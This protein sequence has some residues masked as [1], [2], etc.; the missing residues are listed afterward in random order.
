MMVILFIKSI[1]RKD[2]I[3]NTTTITNPALV[4]SVYEGFANY[5]SRM[6]EDKVADFKK[7]ISSNSQKELE[8]LWSALDKNF[9]VE[10]FNNILGYNI[11]KELF[12]DTDE[13]HRYLKEDGLNDLN[14]IKSF[15]KNGNPV[16]DEVI[17]WMIGLAK[18]QAS[19]IARIVEARLK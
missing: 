7:G 14:K 8:K 10:T 2:I 17:E 3:M 9:S 12:E 16:A 4:S 6:T 15:V 13:L 18:E 19:D 11:S 1:D 5:I